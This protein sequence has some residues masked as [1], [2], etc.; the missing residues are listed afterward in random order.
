[1]KKFTV[2]GNHEYQETDSIKSVKSSQK[3]YLLW[4]TLYVKKV[5]HDLPLNQKLITRL[6]NLLI[7]M[8]LLD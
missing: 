3:S 4:V 1:M 6:A 7:H 8:L 5:R 2:V